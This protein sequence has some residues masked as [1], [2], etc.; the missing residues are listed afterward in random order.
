MSTAEIWGALLI[1]ILIGF[2]CLA[3]AL[4]EMCQGMPMEDDE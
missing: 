2:C 4:W 1:I 3:A